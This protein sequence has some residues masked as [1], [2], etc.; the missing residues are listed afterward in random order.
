[1]GSGK[2]T[3]VQFETEIKD[4]SLGHFKI[5]SRYFNPKKLDFATMKYDKTKVT[6]ANVSLRLT[7]EFLEPWSG[8]EVSAA[9]AR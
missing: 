7:D 4:E 1:V 2:L 6:G 5:S 8:R 3:A 9:L